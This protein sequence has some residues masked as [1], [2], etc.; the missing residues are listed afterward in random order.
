MEVTATPAFPTKSVKSITK[1]VSPSVSDEVKVYDANQ[2]FP[3]V[4][5]GETK[6]PAIVTTG[7][8]IV[9][10]EVRVKLTV[11]PTLAKLV[12]ALLEEIATLVR[13]GAWESLLVV[14]VAAELVL[15]AVSVKVT[16]KVKVPSGKEET[17]IVLALKVPSAETVAVPDTCDAPFEI[18]QFA[19]E[20]ASPL[21]QRA[22]VVL[23]LL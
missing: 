16:D 8:W 5:V 1:L 20:P 4:L 9:S 22:M 15:P 13:V 2:L 12:L 11:S 7:V 18:V 10:D 6:C 17:L 21:P 3:A 19:K 14:I 23:L